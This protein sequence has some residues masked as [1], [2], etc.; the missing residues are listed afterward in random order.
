F[1]LVLGA[2]VLWMWR[3]PSHSSNESPE[4]PSLPPLR[5][6]AEAN[7]WLNGTAAVVDSLAGHTVL[8]VVWT[9]TDPVAMRL[10]P[11][12]DAWQQAYGRFGLRVVS[13][14]TPEY[15]FAA[16][17]SVPARVV[18][19]LGIRIPVALDPSTRVGPRFTTGASMPGWVLIDKSGRGVM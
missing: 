1:V 7:G 9:D 15:S 17:S 18:R 12:A 14:H 10:L 3:H 6:L 19:R 8:V 13:V 16:D 2:G 4:A 5:T 11:E